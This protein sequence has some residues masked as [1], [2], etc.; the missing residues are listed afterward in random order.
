MQIFPAGLN[1]QIAFWPDRKYRIKAIMQFFP[2][3]ENESFA[4]RDACVQNLPI[5]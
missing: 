1:E 2:S 5:F 4:L 3:G